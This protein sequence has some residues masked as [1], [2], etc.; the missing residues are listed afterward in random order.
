MRLG[1]VSH[2]F[3]LPPSS[4]PKT[5]LRSYS[6]VKAV[7]VRLR[8]GKPASDILMRVEASPWSAKLLQIFNAFDLAFHAHPHV[9]LLLGC[10]SLANFRHTNVA[11]A[12]LNDVG[13]GGAEAGMVPLLW[14]QTILELSVREMGFMPRTPLRI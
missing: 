1:D 5:V 7:K 3:T 8:S 6:V 2:Q 9:F 4:C 13:A 12:E 10:E 11:R 14:A